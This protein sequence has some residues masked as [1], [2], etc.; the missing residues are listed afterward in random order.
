MEEH[1][2]EQ[3]SWAWPRTGPIRCSILK[4][5][6]LHTVAMQ[7]LRP[8]RRGGG[9]EARRRFDLWGMVAVH[10]GEEA[11]QHMRIGDACTRSS[12]TLGRWGASS[13]GCGGYAQGPLDAGELDLRLGLCLDKG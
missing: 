7:A 11:L 4:G 6:W 2:S 1:T 9:A 13:S 10:G 8:P 12:R 5:R 3:G